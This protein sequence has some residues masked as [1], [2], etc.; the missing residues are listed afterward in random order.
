[1]STALHWPVVSRPLN[2]FLDTSFILPMQK[3]YTISRSEFFVF[4][5]VRFNI[6]QSCSR[7]DQEVTFSIDQIRKTFVHISPFAVSKLKYVFSVIALLEGPGLGLATN[8]KAHSF[9]KPHHRV[10][11][12]V[13]LMEVNFISV[14][15]IVSGKTVSFFAFTYSHLLAATSCF[16]GQLVIEL[17]LI[18]LL[19]LL[20]IIFIFY[21]VLL[22]MLNFVQQSS[23]PYFKWGYLEHQNLLDSVCTCFVAICPLPLVHLIYYI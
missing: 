14:I 13:D 23:I 18:I 5:L 19:F 7:L 20:R 10:P 15:K 3:N 6:M 22:Q 4:L 8:S 9:P 17:S 1:M 2:L 12:A 11:G 16:P 21:I